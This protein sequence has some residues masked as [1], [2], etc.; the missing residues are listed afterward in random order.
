MIT[1]TN[2]VTATHNSVT[3]ST[4]SKTM[5]QDAFLKLLVT[6][7]ANQ[8]PLEPMKD[9]EFIAQMAQFSTL[10]QMQ[11]MNRNLTTFMQGFFDSQSG[12]QAV[13]LIG[14]TIT[15]IDPDD[16]TKIIEGKVDFVQFDAGLALLRIGE[17]DVPVSNVMKVE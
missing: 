11:N 8:D 13:G 1:G 2:S 10:E 5:G 3:Q 14:K 9:Q 12:Y 4:T 16:P 15:A 17:K 7:L 6:Q